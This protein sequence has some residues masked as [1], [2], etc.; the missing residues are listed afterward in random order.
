MLQDAPGGKCQQ[1]EDTGRCG[2]KRQADTL[3][4]HQCSPRLQAGRHLQKEKIA[5][6]QHMKPGVGHSMTPWARP[7]G[8][9]VLRWGKCPKEAV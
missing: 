1:G 9:A 4:A 7:L 2:N 3:G 8:D 6:V 5:I